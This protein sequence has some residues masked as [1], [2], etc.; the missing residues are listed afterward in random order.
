MP[1]K[2]IDYTKAVIYKI[3]HID[4]ENLLYIGSTTDFATRKSNHKKAC[5]NTSDKK[6]NS[7][8]YR[9]IRENGGWE[10][11]NMVVIP[12]EPCTTKMEL[13]TLEDKLM[14]QMRSNMNTNKAHNTP[15][16]NREYNKQ[17]YIDN[18]E[19]LNE[20]QKQYNKKNAEHIKSYQLQYYIDNAELL[21]EKSKEYNKKNTE[22]I[23][24]QKKQYYI[25]NTEQIKEKQK[26]YCIENAEHFKEKSK[27][28]YQENKEQIAIKAAQTVM[29]DVCKKSITKGSLNRHKKTKKC[30]SF[31][32]IDLKE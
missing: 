16:E 31:L 8:V 2:A 19:L 10:K 25:D 1:L 6:R 20:K 32:K 23:K 12:T 13:L 28:Y 18:T 14:R 11:F 15:D 30:K 7:M 22:Q 27:E 9:M 29:C 3:Q 17:Y 26:Q 5:N 4:I 21:N 24:E